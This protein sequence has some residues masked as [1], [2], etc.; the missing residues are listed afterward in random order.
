MLLGVSER[1]AEN[2][3]TGLRG[4]KSG[5]F[6]PKCVISNPESGFKLEFTYINYF[7]IDQKFHE[8][9]MD[10]FGLG[11][12]VR[13]QELRDLIK[14]QQNL[15]CTIILTP[16][17]E[18][19]FIVRYQQE[20]LIFNL[21][22]LIDDQTDLSKKYPEALFQENNSTGGSADNKYNTPEQF[23]A[24]ISI[25]LHLVEP[26]AYRLRHIQFNSMFSDATMEAIL[27][28]IGQQIG[29][30]QVN[31]APPDNTQSYKNCV[32]PPM[33][34]FSTIFPFLQER[35]GIY[36][37]DIGYYF[38][39]K[40]MYVYPLYETTRKQSAANG[41]LHL[42]NAPEKY[43]LGMDRYFS[44]VGEDKYIVSVT[45][46]DIQVLATQGVENVGN[47]QMS[48]NADS[49][50]DAFVQ[51]DGHGGI[52]R[53]GGDI[54]SVSMQN[55]AVNMTSNTQNVKY[56]GETTNLYNSTS[57][58][59]AI[60]GMLLKL[61]WL[62]AYPRLI[63]PGHPIVYHYD[64]PKSE[65]KTQNGRVLSVRYAGRNNPAMGP[66]HCIIF[67]AAINAKLEPDLKSSSSTQI[68]DFF[69]K[70]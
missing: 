1:L 62:R 16:L 19:D 33:H 4:D 26:E 10:M 63:E 46:K 43:F 39:D 7:N 68:L 30:S 59:A 29:A 41:V 25:D 13:P 52:V 24:R 5:I 22:V 40:K 54:T 23:S 12:D 17:N 32:I 56:N 55:T 44:E 20:Q 37:K 14:N 34:S 9:Y 15:E 31:V 18:F 2:I 51:S 66:E 61:G 28:W 67:D 65:Y 69:T 64:A 21:K 38:T 58:M 11:V 50:L 3:M 48:T 8:T 47:V 6:Q 27:H 42:L 70:S 57:K 35:Y 60:D 45:P 36:S 53:N 49:T